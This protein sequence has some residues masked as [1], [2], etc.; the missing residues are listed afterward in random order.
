M[1]RER[2]QM[3]AM[4]WKIL[5]L[6]T[7]LACGCAVA[8]PRKPV[9]PA[10]PVSIPTSVKPQDIRPFPRELIFREVKKWAKSFPGTSGVVC[11]S[12][13]GGPA[14]T[15]Q[16]DFCFESASLVKLSI[17][18]EL[19]HRLD[20]GS[21]HLTDRLTFEE[22]HRVGG[23]GHLKE[24]PAGGSYSLGE[25]ADWMI[26]ESDN[27]ATDMLL[28]SLHLRAIEGEM[29]RLGLKHTTV[30]RTIFD[31]DEIDKGHDNRTSAGDV[32]DLMSRIG[33]G[34]LPQSA[35]MLGLLEKTRRRDLIGKRLPSRLRMAH[36]SGELTGVLH[37][38]A[39]VYVDQ[40]YLLVIM[41]SGQKADSQEYIQ[42]LSQKIYQVMQNPGEGGEDPG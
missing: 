24:Q 33:R 10:T 27:V 12:L 5:Y 2:A 32:A 6:L 29:I 28:E 26:T 4:R 13:A 16:P 34:E 22:R 21:C 36:K 3:Q 9:A 42:G 41:T 35:W 25:L 7:G 40:P 11:Q 30:Q 8:P 14:A 38:A 31:F 37:D 39:I 1:G 17:L 19:A 15:H 23:S 18:V 20:S